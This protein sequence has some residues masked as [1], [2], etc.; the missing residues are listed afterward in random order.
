MTRDVAHKQE[1]R[2]LLFYLPLL[3]ESDKDERQGTPKLGVKRENW[4]A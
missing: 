1:A 4:F 2:S 3:S